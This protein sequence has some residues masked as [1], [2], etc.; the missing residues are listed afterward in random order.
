MSLF[1]YIC[2]LNISQY[3]EVMDLIYKLEPD[4]SRFIFEREESEEEGRKSLFIFE[5]DKNEQVQRA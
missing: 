2:D 1:A 4:V 5:R 3:A